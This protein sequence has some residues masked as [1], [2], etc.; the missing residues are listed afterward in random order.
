MLAGSDRAPGAE[1][2]GVLAGVDVHALGGDALAEVIAGCE[3][4]ISWAQARQLAAITVLEA[5]MGALVAGLPGGPGSAVD[6]AELTVAEVAIALTV[7]EN[8][9]GNRVALAGALQDCP[10]RRRPWRS[11]RSTSA[12]SG[13]SPRPRRS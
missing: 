6:A 3:R 2:A 7:L 9:A 11:G 1:L 4:L 13:R 12:G 5:R 10:K 8:S